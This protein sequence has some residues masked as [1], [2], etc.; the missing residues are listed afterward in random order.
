MSDKREFKKKAPPVQG[1]RLPPHSPEAEQG[2]LGSILLD[3]AGVM[4][5]CAA[6]LK[7]GAETFYDLRHQTIYDAMADMYTDGTAIDL[8]TL[9]QHL[10]DKA[11]L[12]HVGGLAYL[13]TLPDTTPSA[14]NCDYYIGIVV[15]K[16]MLRK[17]AH[18][19]TDVLGSVFSADEDDDAKEL[20]SKAQSK[21]VGLTN[22]I[23]G[24]DNQN[25]KTLVSNAI[26]RIEGYHQ[27]QGKILGVASGLQ[28]LDRMTCGF[29][30]GE[31]IVFG[32]R[33]SVGKT[34]L[35]M[36]VVENAAVDLNVPCGVFSLEMTA[37][38]LVERMLASRSRVN[39]RQL[40]DG[41]IKEGDVAKLV[42]NSGRLS[43]APIYIDDSGGLSIL[44]L[45]AKARRMFKQHG[46]KLFVI[47]YLQL[48]HTT[49]KRAEN[50][51]Q[52]IADISSGCKEL[53]KELHVPVVVLS[54][55]NREMEKDKNRKPRL[56][57]LRESGG[58]EQDADVIALL[59]K[60]QDEDDDKFTPKESDSETIGCVIAKQ[61]NG[62][63]GDIKFT[64]LKGIT[65]FENAARVQDD[66]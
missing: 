14:A 55:L 59:Y 46:I 1:D 63:T 56:S 32:A 15:E 44:E 20:V 42:N 11:L 6:K 64:F 29:Q 35:A 18:V 4:D 41:F 40:K 27:N 37:D 38:S 24:G 31:M 65:R 21:I 9:Q 52:E 10:K 48:L 66:K 47:D 7:A 17:L 2:I 49:N 53:A 57:D 23:V 22:L 61:R 36:Q 39:I 26:T 12:E 33:P 51:Q 16:Y 19:C 13:T 45:R 30:P 8:I 34:S 43:K 50:R 62:P 60:S 5:D 28:D 3:P 58:I 54:Q 25:M